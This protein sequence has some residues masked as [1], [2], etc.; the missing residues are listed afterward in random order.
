MKRVFVLAVL[1]VSTVE[2]AVERDRMYIVLGA[3]AIVVLVYGLFHKRHPNP[4]V[5]GA[6]AQTTQEGKTSPRDMDGLEVSTKKMLKAD[7]NT[8]RLR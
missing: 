3:A 1:I 5:S 6:V 7:L 2:F 4:V 8:G